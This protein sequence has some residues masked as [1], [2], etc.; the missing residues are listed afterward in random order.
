MENELKQVKSF[1]Y[2]Q[3]KQNAIN[4]YLKIRDIYKSFCIEL[5][6]I[7]EKCLVEK[8]IN[9]HSIEARAKSIDSLGIKCII[10]S[11]FDQNKPK[12]INPIK[13]ITDLAGIR[14]ITFFPYSLM[15]VDKIIN[16]EF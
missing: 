8:K 12:Y 2:E 6:G 1:D 4:E 7:L 13:Q 9:F 10:P 3:H 14:I 11:E 16:S 15:D 5:K